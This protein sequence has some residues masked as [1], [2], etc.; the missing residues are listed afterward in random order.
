M[1]NL[2]KSSKNETGQMILI[3]LLY[4]VGAVSVPYAKIAGF[5]APDNNSVKFIIAFICK[6]LC[7]VIPFILIAD[8]GYSDLFKFSSYKFKRLL[9]IIPCLLVAVNNF[10][11]LPMISGESHMTATGIVIPCFVLYCLSIGILEESIFRGLIFPLFVIKFKKAKNGLF[12]AIIVSSAVFGGMH[13]INLIGNWGAIGAV[14]TQIGYSFLIGAMCAAAM[15]FTESIWIP[16]LLH[17]T[18]DFGG[19]FIEYLGSGNIW[20]TPEII[21]TA[22]LAV[23][24]IIYILFIFIKA[25]KR[26]FYACLNLTDIKSD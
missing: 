2:E 15:F 24:V 21:L 7:A 19:Y 25:D 26:H 4:A 3:V 8:F 9:L 18:F 23:I 11:I 14:I 10:P 13:I 12:W 6:V 16:I 22:V 1:N 5:I 20:S 17:A